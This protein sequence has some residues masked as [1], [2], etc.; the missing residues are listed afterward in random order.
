MGAKV[1]LPEKV[2]TLKTYD[3]NRWV[4]ILPGDITSQFLFLDDVTRPFGDK[5]HHLYGEWV[6]FQNSPPRN[7]S[8]CLGIGLSTA[9]YEISYESYHQEVQKVLYVKW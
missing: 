3:L 1:I 4:V 9:N 7:I 8:P 5:L 2:K 6:M